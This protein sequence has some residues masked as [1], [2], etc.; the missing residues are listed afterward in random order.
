MEILNPED[1]WPGGLEVRFTGEGLSCRPGVQ[2]HHRRLKHLF[3]EAGI[4]PWLRPYVPRLFADGQLIAVG[5]FWRCILDTAAT[6]ED[7][8]LVWQ[9][10]IRDH[11]GFG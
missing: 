4:P 11:P 5:D 2:G 10:G 3:Q 6:V 7:W 8:V 1:R 9:G